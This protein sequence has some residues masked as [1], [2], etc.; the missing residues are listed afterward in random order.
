MAK[1]TK[2]KTGNFLE[3][4]LGLIRFKETGPGWSPLWLL[5]LII[6]NAGISGSGDI[7]EAGS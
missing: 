1:L 7:G 2:N 3:Q 4:S 5:I 6:L